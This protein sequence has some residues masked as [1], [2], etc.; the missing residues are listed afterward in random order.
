M[1]FTIR[2][3][4][5]LLLLPLALALVAPLAARSQAP[6]PPQPLAPAAPDPRAP[7]FVSV[8][9]LAQHLNDPNLVL[10]HV[11]PAPEYATAHISGARLVSVPSLSI[12]DRAGPGLGVEMPSADTLLAR[13]AV[14]G[15]SDDSRVVVYYAKDMV[16]PASR[17]LI[18]LTYAGLGERA[19]LLDGGM[20]AWTAAGHATSAETSRARVSVLAP[21]RI[22][23]FVV[24]ARYVRSMLGAPGV[25]IVDARDT[26]FYT[27]ARAGGS[28]QAPQ[29][30][31]RVPG[32]KSVVWSTLTDSTFRI[33]PASE[34]SAAFAAAGVRPGDL[35]I[36]YCHTGQ[37]ASAMLLAA[38]SLGHRVLL[39]DGSYQDWSARSEL[40][41]ETGPAR[42]K[43]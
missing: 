24:D 43:D 40:P 11:G 34:L 6:A 22:R 20:G 8:E 21:L 32:A 12:G 18:T 23:N 42:P 30:A 3:S 33:R 39:Y 17:I 7:L 26:V 19:S 38:R 10:L 13:L 15:I 28:A 2:L 27:G 41:V 36:G 25:S 37:Q 31:G 9:W 16:Y 29:R 4:V 35:V 14:L 5:R 1:T